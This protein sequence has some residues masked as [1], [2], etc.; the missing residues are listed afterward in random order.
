MTVLIILGVLMGIGILAWLAKSLDEY[1][2]HKYKFSMLNRWH[3]GAL[4]AALALTFLAAYLVPEEEEL[5]GV[6]RS[7]TTFDMTMEA[8]NSVVLVG[9]ALI[10][11]LVVLARLVVNTNFLLGTAGFVLLAIAAIP[12]VI[13]AIMLIFL[14]IAAAGNKNDKNGKRANKNATSTRRT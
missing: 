3:F 9:L 8:S 14:V 2:R 6:L 4:V 11:C 5:L 1:A 10:V 7:V 13:V 12:A